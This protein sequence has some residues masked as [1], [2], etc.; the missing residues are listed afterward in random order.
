MEKDPLVYWEDIATTIDKIQKAT[1]LKAI[2]KYLTPL[3]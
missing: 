3:P 2:Q 1:F